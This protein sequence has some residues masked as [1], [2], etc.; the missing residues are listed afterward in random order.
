MIYIETAGII[1]V[2]GTRSKLSLPFAYSSA[3]HSNIIFVIMK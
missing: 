1:E 3:D 2:K